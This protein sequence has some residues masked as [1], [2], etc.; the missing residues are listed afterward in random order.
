MNLSHPSPPPK[1]THFPSST[2]NIYAFYIKFFAWQLA[3]P[4]LEALT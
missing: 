3:T 2:H 4:Q 1:K